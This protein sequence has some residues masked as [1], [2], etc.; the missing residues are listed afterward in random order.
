MTQPNNSFVVRF[1]AADRGVKSEARVQGRIAFPDKRSSQPN[2]GEFWRVFIRGEN[3]TK[4]VFFLTCIEK[5]EQP[6]DYQSPVAASKPNTSQDRKDQ[7]GKGNNGKRKGNDRNKGDRR[8]GDRSKRD[9]RSHNEAPRVW[10]FGPSTETPP[11]DPVAEKMFEQGYIFAPGG[12]AYEQATA[13]LTPIAKVDFGNVQFA[14][15]Q[16]A[17]LADSNAVALAYQMRAVIVAIDGFKESN[18]KLAA[19]LKGVSERDREAAVEFVAAKKRFDAATAAKQQLQLD[20]LSYGRLK[21][22]YA[23]DG[24]AEDAEANSHLAVIK[25]DLDTR[26]TAV[27]AEFEAAK[28]AKSDAEMARHFA[29]S[30]EEVDRAVA[31]MGELETNELAL[32]AQAADLKEKVRAYEDLIHRLRKAA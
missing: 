23:K 21:Q 17:G 8:N 14:F 1:V 7:H 31:I 24:K 20:T 13:W 3:P 9:D 18:N 5:V 29:Y 12:D 30:V 32:A 25:D 4:T 16:R 11:A 10:S 28:N 2:A 19:D 15:A 22:R 26:R 6:A 27:N